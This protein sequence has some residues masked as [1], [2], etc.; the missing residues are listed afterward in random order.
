MLIF[1]D[2]TFRKHPRTDAN[3]G[4][5]S[6]VA[7][8]E[9][10]FAS[11]QTGLYHVRKPYEGVVLN[12][13]DEIRG[14]LL[15]NAATLNNR[16]ASRSSYKW[17]LAEELL[18]YAR[19]QGMGV[20]GVVCFESGMHTFVCEDE[21]HM[22]RTYRYLFERIDHY[23]RLRFPGRYAKIIFDDRDHHTNKKNARAITNFFSRSS[24]GR[25]FDTIIRTPMFATSQGHNLGLQLADLVTTVI[26]LRFQGER[27]VIPL[28]QLVCDMLHTPTVGGVKRSSLKVMRQRKEK[29]TRRLSPMTGP[30]GPAPSLSN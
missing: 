5:L 17:N 13:G 22:D 24:M 30:K 8:P 10:L 12:E 23:M 29:E 9:D 27:R 28:Y 19:R 20:F 4:V 16:E 3:L 7:I 15:L 2:E 25:G 1:L 18:Q 6:G 21:N 14:R 11:V 26:G